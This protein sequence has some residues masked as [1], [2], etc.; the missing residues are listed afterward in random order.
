MKTVNP[1]LA[2]SSFNLLEGNNHIYIL[3]IKL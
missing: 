2:Y 3:L 1:F